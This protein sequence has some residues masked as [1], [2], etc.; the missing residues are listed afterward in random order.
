[1]DEELKEYLRSQS[2]DDAERLEQTIAA[3]KAVPAEEIPRRISFVSDKVFEPNWWQRLFPSAA[4]NMGAAAIVAASILGHGYL[5]RPVAAVPVAQAVPAVAQ[6]SSTTQAESLE[7][8]YQ[9]RLD[10][11]VRKL[12]VEQDARFRMAVA[13]TEKRMA[14][15]HRAAMVT[16]EENFN[17]MRKQMNRMI[18]ASAE[19]PAG[20][21]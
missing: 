17:L 12:T 1:M 10:E 15:E 5:A 14:F 13:E 8:A 20:Q 11:A 2:A 18:L 3:L 9:R 21:R 19:V 7:A 16:V 6:P 4:W